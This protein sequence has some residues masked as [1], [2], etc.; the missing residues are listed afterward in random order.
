MIG[1]NASGGLVDFAHKCGCGQLTPLPEMAGKY[2]PNCGQPVGN[3][4]AGAL[5]GPSA[6]RIQSETCPKCGATGQKG[7]H[8]TECGNKLK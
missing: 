7:K 4:T 1:I 2:C 6:S 3:P 8:C 5:A